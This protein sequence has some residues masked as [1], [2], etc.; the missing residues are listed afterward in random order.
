LFLEFEVMAATATTTANAINA[1]D[2]MLDVNLLTEV[3]VDE[4]LNNRESRDP[5]YIEHLASLIESTGG[6][7]QPI[8]VYRTP[9]ERATEHG[10]KYELGSGYCRSAALKLL[11]EQHDNPAWVELVPAVLRR[12][13]SLAQRHIDQLIENLGRK[14][15]SQMEE[16]LAFK[17]AIGDAKAN[18][19]MTDLSKKINW[20]VSTVSNYLKVANDLIPE[21]QKLVLDGKMTWSH[22]KEI[23]AIKPA[24]TREQ[25]IAE[26]EL[27]TK[28]S[29]ADFVQHLAE[30]YK[31]AAT[32]TATDEAPAADGAPTAPTSQQKT[33][34]AIR[35]NVLKDKYLPKLTA[36][37]AVLKGT[38]ALVQQA[39]IDTLKFALN[40]GGT[41]LGASLA[42]WE[43]ELQAKA[44]AEAADKERTHAKMKFIRKLIT[45]IEHA[46]DEGAKAAKAGGAPVDL[47]QA[48]AQARKTVEDS[49][50]A[51]AQAGLEANMLPDGFPVE[52]VDKF[53]EEVM[54]QYKDHGVKKA[55]R[56]AAA[57]AALAAKKAGV[58]VA[59][60][61]NEAAVEA[62]TEAAADGVDGTA[63][64][65][66]A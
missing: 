32:S 49:L 48:M 8:V 45:A 52:S 23:V 58:A 50:A 6:L 37:L 65:P 22:A 14:N 9:P 11:A 25:Q 10:M 18:L 19:T 20:P 57:A 12:E 21:A 15:L 60:T 31:Q 41:E 5:A 26:A 24:L 51:G 55:A 43:A 36:D 39:R 38:D 35:S 17:K 28:M 13:T 4:E 40:L 59:E 42:P 46:I 44:D 3:Y 47:P 16:A 64:T 63:P 61:P 30:T 29:H 7:L 62:A 34:T 54:F 33:A 53:M 66:T 56:A 27:A 2:E 1:G